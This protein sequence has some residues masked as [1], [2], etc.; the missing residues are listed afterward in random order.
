VVASL[1][2]LSGDEDSDG[3]GVVDSEEG[4]GDSDLDGVPDYL[5]SES[6][7]NELPEQRKDDAGYIIEGDAVVSLSLGNYSMVSES[8]GA[9]VHAE[10]IGADSDAVNV[11][12][13][14]DF[15]VLGL[16]VHGRSYRV[17]LPQRQ[18]VPEDALYRKYSDDGWVDFVVDEN[19]VLRSA[20]GEP[21]YCPPPGSDE[22]VD[23]LV[24]GSWCVE[25]TLEDGGP[26]DADGTV[27]GEIQDP[28]GVAVLATGNTFPVAVDDTVTVLEN[29]TSLFDVLAND[30]DAD[31]DIL[32]IASGSSGMY[33]ETVDVSGAYLSYSPAGGF[34]GTSVLTYSISDGNGG[35]D[36]AEVAVTVRTNDGPEAVDDSAST[37]DLRA[38]DVSVLENDFDADGD[39]L[40]VTGAS[41]ETEGG[42]SVSVFGGVLTYTPQRG[43][44]GTASIRYTISDGWGGTDQ[45]TANIAVTLVESESVKTKGGGGAMSPLWLLAGVVLTAGAV[46]K[47]RFSRRPAAARVLVLSAVLIAL[48]LP[49]S[50]LAGE[51]PWFAGGSFGISDS[52]VDK[53]EL[54][55]KLAASGYDALVSGVDDTSSAYRLFVGRSLGDSLGIEAGYLDLGEVE[56]TIEGRYTDVADFVDSVRLVH[57]F[58]A[59][60]FYVAGN[61]NWYFYS[62]WSLLVRAGIYSWDS[63]YR[64][65]ST[66]G[67][68]TARD[69]RNG[70]DLF[71]GIGG[72]YDMTSSWSVQ[73]L[74]ER[75]DLDGHDVDYFNAGVMY[76]FGWPF[77]KK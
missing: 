34:V 10:E 54:N 4:S 8:G 42:G 57:P 15:Q 37:D 12:G 67:S 35:V 68:A 77:G 41:L 3:D 27:N 26:N 73:A 64:T 75:F 18:P 19:N 7:G 50:V 58:S 44:S 60:G 23:G 53:A 49:Q 20:P 33:G 9:R 22:Y 31:G 45:A 13:I 43:F 1:P 51:T 47:R 76:R 25:L 6:E 5:D 59:E 72:Q 46:L 17:V 39:T 63:D 38:V 24:A 69:G 74:W 36:S 52:H 70:T 16:P 28:G 48:V 61:Y 21:G 11:G 40:T 2:T 55:R 32:S 29:S 66:G 14:F 62:D 71:Y 56:L 30:T 65:T